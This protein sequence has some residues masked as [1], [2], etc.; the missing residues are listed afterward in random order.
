MEELTL[1]SAAGA[2]VDIVKDS[3][4]AAFMDDVIQVSMETPVIVDFWAP[5]CGPCKQLGPAIEKI[6]KS[7]NGAVKLVKIDIDQNPAIAQQLRV[8]SIP[9]VFAFKGGQPVDGFMGAVPE[10][11]IKEFVEKLIG[12]IAPTPV[13]EAL[14]AGAAA[15]EQDDFAQAAGLY[16]EVLRLES[17]NVVALVGLAQ[18][19]I[20]GG[21]LERAAQTLELI[22]PDESKNPIVTSVRAALTLAEQALDAG[23]LDPLLAQVAANENDHQARYDLSDALLA[24]GRK[25]E[26]VEALLEIVRRDRKWQD[27]GARKQLLTLFEAFGNEDEVTQDGRQKLS[28]LLFS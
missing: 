3:S 22:N 23:D 7:T 17:S 12:E 28:I 1:P 16:G 21:D 14:V 26:A 10:S 8:Q 11:Q 18:C 27:D 13:E 4:D 9:A 20:G 25:E 5:W 2:P 24:A 6:V 15:L 19:Y